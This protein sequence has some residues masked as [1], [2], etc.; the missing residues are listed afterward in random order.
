LTGIFERFEGA[1]MSGSAIIERL[2][3]DEPKL[4]YVSEEL[5][6]QI[7]THTGL[8]F[9]PGPASWAVPKEVIRYFAKVVKSDHRTLE[10]GGGHSTVAL[11]SLAAHH[12]CITPDVIS[13]DLVKAYL[14]EVGI[15]DDRVTYILEPS[16]TALARF[17]PQARLDFA[18]IDGEHAY[19]V[20]AIDWHFVDLHLKVGGIVG[21]DNCE[22]PAVHE[23]CVFLEMNKSYALK[24]QIR[25]AYQGMNY[26]VKFYVKKK[27]EPRWAISQ[28]YNHRRVTRNGLRDTVKTMLHNSLR[29]KGSPWPWS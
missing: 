27:D 20:P 8:T 25:D 22:I 1:P 17:Q 11:A 12:T 5:S 14:K 29:R 26:L 6:Q 24:D 18:F 10:T 16:D 7:K 2:I 15:P 23:H 21:F 9:K 4:H 28:A 3:R 19:P 13:T